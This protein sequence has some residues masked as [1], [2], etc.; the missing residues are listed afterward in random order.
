MKNKKEN[1][2][3]FDTVAFFRNV[4]EQIARE[5]DGKSFEQQKIILNK[6]LSGEIKLQTP[7]I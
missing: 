2:K 1:E 5:L 4:K 7:A 3:D 6:M